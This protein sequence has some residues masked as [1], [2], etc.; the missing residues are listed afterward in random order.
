MA[1]LLNLVKSS[2]INKTANICSNSLRQLN[3]TDAKSEM[4]IIIFAYIKV[5][6]YAMLVCDRKRY[7][8]E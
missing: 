5:C 7:M 6:K 4:L 1:I 2:Y 3:K 8:H